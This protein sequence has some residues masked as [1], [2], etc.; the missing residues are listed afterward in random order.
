MSFLPKPALN[1]WFTLSRV[2]HRDL[3]RLHKP[4]TAQHFVQF[5]EDD[6]LIIE[7]VSY[8]AAKALAAGNS[9]VIVATEPHRQAIERRLA[10]LNLDLSRPCGEGRCVFLDAAET[11]SRFMVAGRPDPARFDEVVGGVIANA[12]R[13][14]A[15]GF[16]FAFGEM[17][18]L[19]CAA[20]NSAAAVYLERLWN[21]LALRDRFSLYCAYPLGSLAV[22]PDADALTQICAEHALAIPAEGPL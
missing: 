17:V 2:P 3:L 5:Y 6:S 10:D 4:E 13:C 7:N 16:A 14:S 9:S 20:G 19:L 22:E 11:L 21:G 1:D 18:A 15:S 12:V 8:L